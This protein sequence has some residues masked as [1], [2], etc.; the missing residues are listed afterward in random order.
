M[1]EYYTK[2]QTDLQASVIGG[3]IKAAKVTVANTLG[4]STT[5]AVSQKLLTDVLGD[6]ETVL[7][8]LNGE[9]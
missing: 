2:V 9:L 8:E 4:Q 1:S 7:T 6:I 5:Q 3:R